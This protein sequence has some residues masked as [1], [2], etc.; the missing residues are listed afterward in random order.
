MHARCEIDDYTSRLGQLLHLL[1]YQFFY[2]FIIFGESLMIIF[3]IIIIIIGVVSVAIIIV[4]FIFL[5]HV[6]VGLFGFGPNL[7]GIVECNVLDL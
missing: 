5:F 7:F 6:W 3:D 1:I 2:F 4:F